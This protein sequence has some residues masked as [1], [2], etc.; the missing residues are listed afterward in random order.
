MVYG[1][2]IYFAIYYSSSTYYS[3]VYDWNVYYNIYYSSS[4]YYSR[5]YDW[6]VYY[7]IYY[8]YTT[9]YNRIYYN[10]Y[11]SSITHYNRAYD[12]NIYYNYITYYSIYYNR[13]Y[14]RNIYY[15]N[16]TNVKIILDVINPPYEISTMLK[17][18]L[19]N[20]DIVNAARTDVSRNCGNGGSEQFE[21]TLANVKKALNC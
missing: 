10:I 2:H 8:N 4:T 5:V 3:R 6:N 12:C 1:C 21:T 11:Y 9:H 20:S 14:N 18:R 15:Y 17:C 13:V 19:L 16:S 7:N